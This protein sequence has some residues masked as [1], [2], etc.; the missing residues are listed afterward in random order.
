M[1]Y[2]TRTGE[3]NYF[4]CSC[5]NCGRHIE[6]PSN[7]AGMTISCPHCGKNTVLGVAA[8]TS[9]IVRK[10][11]KVLGVT[12]A[13]MV[14]IAGAVVAFIW[15]QKQKVSAAAPPPK[16]VAAP[17]VPV[18]KTNKPV[19]QPAANTISDFDVSKISL[20]K[21]PGSS[22]VYAVGTLKND[23]DRQR[24][25]V[26]IV[27]NQLDEKGQNLGVV[28][29]YVSVVDPQQAW[30]FKAILTSPQVAKVTVAGIREQQ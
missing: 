16:A 4:K 20:Q 24:F 10:S 25:G 3:P 1:I 12:V 29:D 28:S 13:L 14:V 26:K 15:P 7:G 22:L 19:S 27:L 2:T 5:Q 18:E 21:M 6:F 30:Q 11:K 9:P 8:A 17:V 23:V